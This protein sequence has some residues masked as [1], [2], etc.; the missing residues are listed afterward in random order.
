MFDE[1]QKKI[2]KKIQ[3]GAL[4]DVLARCVFV[5]M[6]DEFQKKIQK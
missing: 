6:F 3:S 2:Q 1:F 4:A 5:E